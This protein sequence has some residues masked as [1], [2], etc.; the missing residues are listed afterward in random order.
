MRIKIKCDFL[1]HKAGSS[2]EIEDVEGIP[3]DPYW[4]KR[5]KESQI[6]GL[7]EVVESKP[8]KSVRLKKSNEDEVNND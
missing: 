5:L 6:D 1:E 8:K 2:I 7:I 3:T 4:R